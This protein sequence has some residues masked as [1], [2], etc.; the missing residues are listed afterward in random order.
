[1]SGSDMGMGFETYKIVVSVIY[2][3]K[4]GTWTLGVIVNKVVLAVQY[5]VY[6]VN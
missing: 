5:L 1:M 4:Q 6:E 2:K 3:T